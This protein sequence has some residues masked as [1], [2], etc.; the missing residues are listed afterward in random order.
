VHILRENPIIL[1]LCCM[2]ARRSGHL[3]WVFDC[4]FIKVLHCCLIRWERCATTSHDHLALA[5]EH[6]WRQ[7]NRP[8]LHRRLTLKSPSG[9]LGMRVAT[10]VTMRVVTT[11]L[12]V[13][14]SLASEPET[15]PLIGT[16][17]GTLL[18]SNTS[19]MGSTRLSVR[20]K[21]SDDSSDGWMI[22]Y[23]CKW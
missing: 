19:I 1:Y 17:T 22:L 2:V 9:T 4:T 21:G 15:Q 10:W 23:M 5:D 16:L 18:W 7:H 6:A 8:R 11:P 13:T 20:W 14:L 12:T 3:I